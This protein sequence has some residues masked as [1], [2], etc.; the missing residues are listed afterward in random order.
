MKKGT[1]AV[2]NTKERDHSL[3]MAKGILIAM[4]IFHH[5]N[6]TRNMVGIENELMDYMRLIQKPL[7]VCYF[8]PAFFLISGICS[9]FN[10]DFKPFITNQVKG[11]L[12]PAVSFIIIIHAF[13]GESLRTLGG[14]I[15]RLF[16]YGKDYWFLV[17]L[18]E[19]KVLYYFLRRTIH[20]D[21]LLL[22]VLVCLSLGGAILNDVDKFDNFFMHRHMLDLTFF[23][24]IGNI[25]KQHLQ[26]KR[27]MWI[28]LSAF[29]IIVIPLMIFQVPIPYV[30]YTFGTTS[31]MWPVH[32]SLS[33]TGSI[34]IVALCKR[35]P[36]DSLVEYIGRNSLAIFLMQ[37]YTLIMFMECFKNSLKH[38]P[39]TESV[40]L[41]SVIFISTIAIGLLVAYVT[42]NTKLRYLMGKF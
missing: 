23:I 1:T 8:M 22:L 20:N 42:N 30:T 16:V 9:N 2:T 39:M 4:L 19:A 11:L 38:C 29:T 34:A 12:I 7:I 27:I 40:V 17:A 32:L 13:Q 26:T 25:Y 33:L 6:D 18:F 41:V 21:R 5:I 15:M 35:L 14:T 37:W 24:G 31:F 36:T 28:S 3:D 10:K